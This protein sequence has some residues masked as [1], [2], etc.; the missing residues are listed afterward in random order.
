MTHTI[1]WKYSLHCATATLVRVAACRW[2]YASTMASARNNCGIGLVTMRLGMPKERSS[3]IPRR[4]GSAVRSPGQNRRESNN[5]SRNVGTAKQSAVLLPVSHRLRR[6]LCGEPPTNL[7][8]GV[9]K[10]L[11]Q[12]P[13][14]Q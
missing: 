5:A 10:A 9:D 1:E 3:A 6:C 7:A 2:R 13:A 8:V 12:S 4:D 14:F 11:D